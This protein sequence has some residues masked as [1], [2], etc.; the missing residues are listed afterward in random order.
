MFC[1][2]LPTDLHGAFL[3]LLPLSIIIMVVGGVLG[4]INLLARAHWLLVV[5]GILLIFGGK[6]GFHRLCHPQ[7]FFSPPHP[8][9]LTTHS[10]NGA[11]CS[12]WL[13]KKTSKKGQ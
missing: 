2:F 7:P 1:L 13:K 8:A 11:I 5:T 6:V 12:Y 4:I 9:R 10:S 3:V